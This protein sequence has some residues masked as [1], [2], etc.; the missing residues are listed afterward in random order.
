MS[1]KN[2]SLLSLLLLLLACRKTTTDT[3]VI[4][5]TNK[6][7]G[8]ITLY[9]QALHHTYPIAHIRVHYKLLCN[10]Y[11]GS[12]TSRYDYHATAD[13]NGYVRFDSLL[14]GNGYIYAEGFDPV[15]Q[16]QVKGNSGLLLTTNNVSSDKQ[17][18]KIIYVSENANH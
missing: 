14:Y 5:T 1:L 7:K 13:V 11:P 10:A 17:A 2:L 3:T 12:D 6:M 15:V 16:A 8:P 4:S 18:E 9:V